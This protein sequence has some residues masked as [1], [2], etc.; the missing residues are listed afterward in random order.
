MEAIDK[1]QAYDEMV[2]WINKQVNEPGGAYS[3]WYCGIA[4]D[5]EERVFKEHNVPTEDDQW[6][7]VRKCFNDDDARAVE[8]KLH[9]LGCDGGPRGGDE[10][11]V[12]VYAY[13]KGPTTIEA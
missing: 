11:T 8:T 6:R 9:E 1:K 5:W 12:Y 2:A 13:L 4:A 7:T 10:T 3:K